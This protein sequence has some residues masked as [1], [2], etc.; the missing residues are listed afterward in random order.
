MSWLRDALEA[1]DTPPKTWVK[2]APT[3]DEQSK[4]RRVDSA[5]PLR[6]VHGQCAWTGHMPDRDDPTTCIYDCQEDT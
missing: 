3:V 6:P 2:P 1:P 4:L 5:T